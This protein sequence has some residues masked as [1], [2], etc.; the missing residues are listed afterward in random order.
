MSNPIFSRKKEKKK[1]KDIQLSLAE[2]AHIMVSVSRLMVKLSENKLVNFS[3]F[4]QKM[5]LFF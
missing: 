4:S 1:K 2:F 5:F 3:Y